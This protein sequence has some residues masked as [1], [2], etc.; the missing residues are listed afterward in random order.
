M[1]DLILGL[2]LGLAIAVTTTLYLQERKSKQE[3][4]RFIE[5]LK[6]DHKEIEINGRTYVA[7]QTKQEKGE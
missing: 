5:M 7:K 6:A 4:K 3:R 2:G 1:S